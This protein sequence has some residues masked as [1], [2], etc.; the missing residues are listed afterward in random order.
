[1]T[2]ATHRGERGAVATELVL[3][4]PSLVVVVGLLVAGGRIWL[5]RQ[6][7]EEAA[8]GG[9][10]AAS[11][12][13]SAA[14]ARQL[15]EESVQANVTTAGMTCAPMVL[16]VDTS[17]FAVAPGVPASVTTTVT[18]RISLSDVAVPGLPGA[19]TLSA[20]G[21]SALDTFRSR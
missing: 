1:M 3:L 20:D 11:L 21:E 10:R 18:C 19:M 12:A 16:D 2:A 6:S 7:L 17:G 14:S 15:A 9:A 4:V 8:A 5:A 13:R